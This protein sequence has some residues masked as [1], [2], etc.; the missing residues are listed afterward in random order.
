[1]Y[2]FDGVVL[3]VYAWNTGSDTNCNCMRVC[4][5]LHKEMIIF[6]LG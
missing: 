4:F 2:V 1:M 5:K 6:C 3:V